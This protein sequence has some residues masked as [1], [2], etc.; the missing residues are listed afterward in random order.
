MSN[1]RTSYL[2]SLSRLAMLQKLLPALVIIFLSALCSWAQVPSPL[3]F[4]KITKKEGL[5][6]NTTFSTIQDKQGFLW[7]A[8]QNGLQ[9]YDGARLLTFRHIPGNS[10]SIPDN[11]INRLFIDSKGRLW[12]LGDR[13]TGIFNTSNFKFSKAATDS[14]ILLIKKMMEDKDGRLVMFA[15]NKMFLYDEQQHSF[16]N[17]YTFPSRP[18][19][20]TFTDMAIDKITGL[21]W[22]TGKQGSALY[23]VTAKQF[24]TK[25]NN[26]I[27]NPVLDKLGSVLNARYPFIAKDST[28][29]TVSWLPFVGPPPSVYHY[30]QKSKKLSVFES[31]R[32]YKAD[33]YYE[34]WNFFQQS[35]GTLWIYGMG[36][37]AYYDE[38]QNKFVVVQS[39]PTRPNGIDYD[40]I[41]HLYEDQ[42]KNVWVST[43]KGLY[44]Y[45]TEAQL[46]TSIINKRPGDTTIIP[47]STSGIVQTQS[48]GIWVGTWGSGVFS[49]NDQ[50]Q[51]I[52][53]PITM[54]E[55][56][57]QRIHASS[58]TQRKNG[59]IWVGTHTGVLKIYEP[60]T[61][62]YYSVEPPQLKGLIISQLQE[63]D[64]GNMWVGTTSG[65]LVKCEKGNWKDTSNAYRVVRTDAGDVLKFYVDKNHHLWV[66]TASSGLYEMD[67]ETNK[68]LREFHSNTDNHEGLLNDGASDIIQYN[69]SLFLI[70]NGGI[71]ILNNKTN[72]FRYLTSA[73][74]LP[75]EQ[76][77]NL[78]LDNKKRL[79][80]TADG[81]LYRLNIDNKLY[82]S[83]GAADGIV[84]DIFQV[85]SATVLQDG[86]IALGTPKDFVVF[87]P[88]K[89][90]GNKQA[91]PVII[92]GI[93]SGSSY[94]SVDSIIE[95][96]K[97]VLNYDNT[98]I[99]FELSTLN[100]RDTYYMYY[101]LEGLDKEWKL[102]HNNELTYQF[103][104]AGSY[105][106]K[107]KS[108][109]SEG[110]ESKITALHMQVN[111]PFWQTWWFYSLIIILA[112]A[113][114]FWL[115]H[116][117]VKRK[118]AMLKMRSDIAD[119]LHRDINAALD[120]IT[121]LS[122]MAKLK[123]DSEPEKSKEFIE[124]IHSKSENMTL[125]MSDM[126]WS[127]DPEND[128]MQKLLQRFREHI[129]ALKNENR[130]YID[131]LV[132]KKAE[133][134][135][136]EMNIRND[137]LRLF[138]NGVRSVI[139]TGAKNCRIHITYE[140]SVLIYT[141][142]FDTE[143][144]DITQL[145]NIRLR[146]DL[147]ERLNR[148]NAKLEFNEYKTNAVF[149]LSIP[150]KGN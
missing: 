124:E 93:I 90:V 54:A 125:V 98:F 25:E 117:R 28:W 43:N 18:E 38:V 15:D 52:P 118:T 130:V 33:S 44:R 32:P 59:E 29:W 88:D 1:Q 73:D 65:V 136:L 95:N 5:A 106:L 113:I 122:K 83:Y 137:V 107:L 129:E 147:S 131:L 138:K 61:G 111:P 30:D 135:P 134:L 115:D 10:S 72:K 101:M 69:D 27:K 35:N 4:S 66:C 63:D 92:S 57:N 40:Y 114:L 78:I 148:L 84:N 102:V 49:Y 94:L 42:E 80:V 143:A 126:L 7:I 9:R 77:T 116:S 96:D 45:N 97:L 11:S 41:S 26:T 132:D 39:D 21:Y 85:A 51:P 74:G 149:I 71:C 150:V 62:K 64:A 142:E 22:L 119:N 87:D 109:N 89:T 76:V 48:N 121:I 70:A 100:F 60:A 14:S 19:G 20:Y 36:L 68:I 13:Q 75:A 47:H 2:C 103:L 99:R 37:L 110:A 16:L 145:H 8:T 24:Y 56:R 144:L 112:V 53:N 82:V 108:M 58:L 6:S 31:I 23:D 104:P 86:R 17:P 91:P 141:L 50:L 128:S 127:I 105:T 81:G 67:A 139:R 123:A 79:W 34:V 133:N 146:N 46:F 120:N 3:V 140:R 12:I 55:P